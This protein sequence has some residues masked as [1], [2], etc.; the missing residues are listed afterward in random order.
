MPL[1]NVSHNNARLSTQR[2]DA[3]GYLNDLTEYDSKFINKTS[4]T[5]S[6]EEIDLERRLNE[7]RY[8]DLIAESDET[9]ESGLIPFS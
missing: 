8:A 5:L 4:S 6:S 9:S 3:R 2:Y 7:E 1:I